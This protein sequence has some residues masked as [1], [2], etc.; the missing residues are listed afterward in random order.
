M[1]EY[2]REANAMLARARAENRSMTDWE[3]QQYR[4]CIRAQAGI[5]AHLAL[6]NDLNEMKQE[7]ERGPLPVWRMKMLRVI[8]RTG[9]PEAQQLL[10]KAL[11]RSG[12]NETR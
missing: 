3:L 1:K 9:I 6:L 8:A 2:G 12:E 11:K 4:A 7:C 5:F 10:Q